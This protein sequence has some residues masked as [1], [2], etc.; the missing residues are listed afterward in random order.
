MATDLYDTLIVGGGPAGLTAALHLGWQQRRVL[1]IDRV[2]GPLFFT[3]EQLWNVPG[4]PGATGAEIQKRLKAQA[5][6]RGAEVR[7]GNVVKAEAAEGAFVL[8]GAKGES[9][10]GRTLLLAT[11]VIRYHPTVDGDFTPCFAHAGKGNLFYCTDCEGPEISG[12][13]TIVIGT[14]HAEWAAAMAI[15]LARYTPRLRILATAGTKISDEREWDAFAEQRLGSLQQAHRLD[16]AR[17]ADDCVA[18]GRGAHFP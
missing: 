2:S 7:H 13:D 18:A 1:L 10:R 16:E 11:G 15:G 5:V 6:E 12:R 14:G 17:H 9:W 8:T 4:M 3:L